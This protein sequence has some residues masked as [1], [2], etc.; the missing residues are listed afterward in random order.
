MDE[1]RYGIIGCGMMGIE[2]MLNVQL[3]DAARVVAVADP[4]EASQGWARLTANEAGTPLAVYSDV[5]DMLDREPLDA[6]IVATPNHTHAS[7]LETLFETD[8]HLLVEKPMCTTVEDSLRTVEAAERHRGIFW[9]AMEYRYMPPVTR[10]LE[11]LRAGAVGRLRMLAIRE[12][13]MPF[14]PKVA[15]WNR[16][17]RNSGGTLVEKCCHFFDLMRLLT[18]QEPVRVFASAGQD[19]N[20]LDERYDG[21]VPDILD[22]AFVTVDFDGGARALLDLCMFAEGSRN[23]EEI[24]ATGDRGKLECFIPESTLIVGQRAPRSV[25]TVAVPVEPHL[26]EAGFHHGSTYYEHQ[27]FQAA[28][29]EGRPPEVSA[30]DGLLAVAMGVAAERSAAAGRPVELSELGL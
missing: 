28:I 4:H 6:V 17:A 18:S 27:Q 1:I 5:R 15:N 30:R 26:L 7:V 12:H 22:N 20:H 9:V 14:L 10:M 13:R 23:Q 3:F 25:E 29:R 24:A 21:E 8:L 16:F 19:V 2:H 11:A